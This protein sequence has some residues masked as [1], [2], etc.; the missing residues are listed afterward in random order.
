[1]MIRTLNQKDTN[2]QEVKGKVIRKASL[3]RQLLAA[4]GDKVRIIDVK[5]DREDPTRQRTVHVF[6][7]DDD[8]QAVLEK[9]L[10]ENKKNREQRKNVE[11]DALRKEIEEMKRKFEELKKATET[12][13]DKG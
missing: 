3:T 6:R 12:V 7:D 1:M 10:E 13:A 8:F 4:G 5:V 11:N 9:V 2:T